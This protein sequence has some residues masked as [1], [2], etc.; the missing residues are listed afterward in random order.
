MSSV[1]CTKCNVAKDWE[2]EFYHNKAQG[3]IC[4]ECRLECNREYRMKHT[5][6]SKTNYVDKRTVEETKKCTRCHSTKSVNEFYYDKNRQ[7][8][9]SNCKECKKNQIQGN[10]ENINQRTKHY[11][12]TNVKAR[13]IRSL[14]GRLN[15]IMNKKPASTV[16]M[17]GCSYDYFIRW[18]EYQLYDGM[19]LENYGKIWHLDHCKPCASYDMQNIKECFHWSNIRPLKSEKN[20]K[21]SD[22]V[23]PYELVLQELKATVYMKT[24]DSKDNLAPSQ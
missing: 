7:N 16:D 20:F 4:K 5:R 2:T 21:K 8:Y 1:W 24:L 22:K 9:Q 14:R 23:I 15:W 6:V 11:Y 18:I 3:K 12:Q 17:L 13:L 19:T 10:R